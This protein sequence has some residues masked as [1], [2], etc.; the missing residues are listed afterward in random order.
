MG[1]VLLTDG[2]GKE[3][4]GSAA[5]GTPGPGWFG[6][7]DILLSRD[8]VRVVLSLRASGEKRVGRDGATPCD[9]PPAIPPRRRPGGQRPK[10][11]YPRGHANL[12]KTPPNTAAKEITAT[13][14]VAK[15]RT[16]A[17]TTSFRFIV[18]YDSVGVTTYV[19]SPRRLLMPAY[20]YKK[21]ALQKW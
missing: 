5:P 3:G 12:C 20:S 2:P 8:W 19:L 11:A 13:P 6:L 16:P 4:T 7:V 1:L 9:A 21:R 18:A 17:S 10:A 14:T 15:R